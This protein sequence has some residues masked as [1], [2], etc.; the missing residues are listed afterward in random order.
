MAVALITDAYRKA[1]EGL[2]TAQRLAV[3]TL[4]GPVL[5]LAGPGTGKTQLLA[6][7][8]AH[9]LAQ[10]D[11]EARNVLC[12]TYTDAAAGNMRRRLAQMIGPAASQVTITTFHGFCNQVILERPERFAFRDEAQPISDVE[13]FQLLQR[14]IDQLPVSNP[15]RRTSGNIHFEVK[16]LQ[17]LYS[18]LKRES[19]DPEHFRLGI[20]AYIEMLPR[21]PGFFYK[22]KY[23]EHQAG[24]PKV[25]DIDEETE[26][27][28]RL[29]AALDLYPDYQA[30]MNEAQRYT[31][32]DMIRWVVEAIK[33]DDELASDLQELFHYLL[34]D[35]YQDTSG[36]QNQLV[37]SLMEHWGTDANLLVVGD[38]DQ[39]I[40]RFQGANLDNL[41]D[42][43]HRYPNATVCCLTENYRSTQV[44]LDHAQALIQHNGAHRLVADS[45]LQTRIPGLSK[46]LVARGNV[47]KLP[48]RV[49][50][51]LSFPDPGSEAIWIADQVEQLIAGGVAPG[52][53]AVLY[54]KRRLAQDLLKTLM[55]RR[56]PIYNKSN[57]DLLKEVAVRHLLNL[58][59]LLPQLRAPFRPGHR[60]PSP[61]NEF[62]LLYEVF[63]FPYWEISP[64]ALH[65]LFVGFHQANRQQ[66]GPRRSLLEYILRAFP[67][68]VKPGEVQSPDDLIDA[69]DAYRI[70]ALAADLIEWSQSLSNETPTRLL[71]K[72]LT[73][74][75]WLDFALRTDAS[76]HLL[77]DCWTNWT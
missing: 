44:I 45:G 64:V 70:R 58:L 74:G 32:D 72:I 13:H 49:P 46:D 73:R 28:E 10:T 69:E 48:Q 38:D 56:V 35:E 50:Q 24:D 43:V 55:Q 11:T 53:I 42:F 37:F 67:G 77:R 16:R 39:T 25:K 29:I 68:D 27:M 71:E 4:E 12:L 2:N 8:I 62:E 34:V 51:Y 36:S 14:L 30:A 26:K 60:D 33:Q 15:L 22:R 21:W 54:L 31:F 75:G 17:T 18:T 1:Y 65:T 20:Q 40:Y 23:K 6:T 61:D 76:T 7:R 19:W 59:R 9:L 41:K 63:V 3:D 47:T 52:Q 57:E 66:E 5:V